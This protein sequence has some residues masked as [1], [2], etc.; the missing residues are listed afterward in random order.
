MENKKLVGVKAIADCVG[1]TERTV[2]RWCRSRLV[3]GIPILK[4]GGRYFAFEADLRA[5]MRRDAA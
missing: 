5:W 1:V 2:R 4:A 3:V